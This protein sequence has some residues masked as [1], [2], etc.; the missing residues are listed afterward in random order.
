MF[1]G[2][3]FVR[4]SAAH[5]RNERDFVVVMQLLSRVGVLLIQ[6]QGDRVAKTSKLGKALFQLAVEVAQARAFR[7]RD[8]FMA[9]A[10]DIA[11]HPEIQH[12]HLHDASIA[13][14]GPQRACYS[15]GSESLYP[16]NSGR[17]GLQARVQV[18]TFEVHAFI[19]LRCSGMKASSKRTALTRA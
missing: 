9:A 7:K 3:V 8:H 19:P 11:Q 14:A 5:R 17:A 10:G 12:T 18:A 1:V 2:R 15:V 16:R 13:H 6:R 4:R